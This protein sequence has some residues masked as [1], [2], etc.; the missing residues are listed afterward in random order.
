MSGY[1]ERTITWQKGEMET[2]DGE[3]RLLSTLVNMDLPFM[4]D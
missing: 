2:A 4:E 3:N 1:F